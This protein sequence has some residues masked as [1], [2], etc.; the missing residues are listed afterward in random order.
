MISLHALSS[1]YVFD[2]SN[3]SD[4]IF[5]ICINMNIFVI[6]FLPILLLLSHP[7]LAQTSG[8]DEISSPTQDQDV[9][10]G[11]I[12]NIIW[13]LSS[14]YTGTISL[15]L[16]QGATPATLS[17]GETIAGKLSSY[18]LSWQRTC[19]LYSKLEWRARLA[20]ISGASQVTFQALR[21]TGLRSCWIPIQ[22]S[23]NTASLS[24]LQNQHQEE[25]RLHRIP[26]RRLRLWAQHRLL[27]KQQRR[28]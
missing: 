4:A 19:W 1:W 8:F 14:S 17:L 3:L 7:S 5:I 22:Q 26:E 23:S 11:S 9:A 24:I 21:L 25:N 10:A 20:N 15:V 6:F 18:Q 27:H 2:L 12:L 13:S 28:Q 16:L